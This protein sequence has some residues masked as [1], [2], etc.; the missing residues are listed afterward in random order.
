M[1]NGKRIG[2]LTASASRLGGGVF[3]AVVAH[4]ALVRSLG[5]VPLVFALDDEHATED[6]ARLAPHGADVVTCPIV[7]P[8]QVGMAPAL[9]PALIAANLDCLHLHGIWMYPSS[10][11]ARWAQR[12]GRPYFVSPHGMLDPWITA[13]GR[14]K[15]A[16]ARIGYERAS[17][18]RATALH[19]L[20][21]REARDIARET[22]RREV[23]VI[24]NAGPAPTGKR[25][26]P[27][28]LNL[29]YIGRIHTK[30]NL[31]AL[32]EGWRIAA[33]PANARLTIAGWGDAD[34]VAALESAVAQAD[35]TVEFV[36]PVYGER[37][38]AL[39]DAAR[40]VVL[41]SHSEGLPMAILEAW[42]K[43][44]PTLMTA[45]CNLEEG[46]T[47]GAALECGY[48]AAIIA[49]DLARAL[50]M[51]DAQ[52]LAMSAAALELAGSRFSEQSVAALWGKTYLGALEN[53]KAV[54]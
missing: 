28:G 12:T 34:D 15:K 51:P 23:V 52:W 45:E 29:L 16:L 9:T 22:G 18:A 49:S 54:A 5:G 1:L 35:G 6:R 44:T 8:R 7:G 27:A 38:Q 30:K 4:A 46:F 32:V 25:L 39:L 37:K 2:L 36:G 24:P 21:A 40:F 42:S 26:P 53:A 17:W 20:T 41:P 33:R 50:A 47:A 31:L 13:R 11:G 3:E 10:A 19:G 14:W 43:G 48:D